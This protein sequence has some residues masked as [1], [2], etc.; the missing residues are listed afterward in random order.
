MTGG[1]EYLAIPGPSVMPDAVLR[2]MHRAAAN[3]YEGELV[4]MMPGLIADLNYVAGSTGHIALY[5]TNGHGAWEA[6]LVNMLSRGD[7]VLSLRTGR[8]GMIWAEFAAKLGADVEI[9]DFGLASPVDPARLEARLRA[10]ANHEFKAI[11]V[12]ATDTATSVRNDLAAIRAAIDAA[13]H[14]AVFAVDAVAALGCDQIEMDAWGIDML[15]TACQKGLMTPP[16]MAMLFYNDKADALRET[17]DMVTPYWDWRRRTDPES[18][19]LYFFGTAPT[20]HIWGLRTALD[21][22]KA[23]GIEAV[24]ARHARLARGIWAATETWGQGGALSLNIAERGWRSHAVTSLSLGAG[25]G[26]RLREWTQKEAGLTLG[27][28]MGFAPPE[29]PDWHRYFRVGH[30][31]HINTQMVLGALG[32]IEAGLHALKIPYGEGALP[33]A[34]RALATD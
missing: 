3:I 13:G 20:Q 30:M 18:F 23:E 19:Y 11:L 2:S 32:T 7:K 27:I 31:G 8:F 9:M 28:G 26:T 16:G 1:R 17:A 12:T 6:S 29:H 15:M 10:D 21:M 14:P 24:W 34:A 4:E 5:V 25:D 33:A 22:I